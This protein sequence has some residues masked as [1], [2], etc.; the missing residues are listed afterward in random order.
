MHSDQPALPASITVLRPRRPMSPTTQTG[1][2]SSVKIFVIAFHWQLFRMPYMVQL[3]PTIIV[4][5]IGLQTFGRLKISL[6]NQTTTPPLSP[7]RKCL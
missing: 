7:N 4:T 2:Q 1:K 6:T 3:N 5:D